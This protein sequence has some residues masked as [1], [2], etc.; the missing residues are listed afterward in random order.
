MSRVF[1]PPLLAAIAAMLLAGGCAT[2]GRMPD[3]APFTAAQVAVM[4]DVGFHQT[5]RGWEFSM[6]DRLL[7]E[8]DKS[9]ILPP[10]IEAIGRI[11][12]QLTDVHIA[13]VEVEG[14]T[15]NTGSVQHNDELSL[16]RATA[17]ADAMAAAGMDRAGIKILGLGS[18][19][20]VESNA[21]PDGR[22]E[23]RRVV[24]LITAP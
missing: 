15:D 7:F 2:T 19:Y 13:H 16:R 23:N 5:D 22:R 17:V 9:D 21:T 12:R 24:I 8:I 18:R 10:Q 20:P 1:R 3:T 6:A 4:R 11:A 14:H